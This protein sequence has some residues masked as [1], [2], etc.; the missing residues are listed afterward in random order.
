MRFRILGPLEVWS[1]DDWIDIGAAKWRSLLACLLLR[2][3]QIVSTETLILELW[4]DNPPAKANNLV[5]IY[6]HRLRRVIGDAEGRMLVYRAPGY[7][8]RVGPDDTDMQQ[9]ESL[10]GK[11]RG[12][13]DDGD[14]QAAADLLEQ[15]LGLWR[16]PLLADVPPSEL[17]TRESER[18]AELRLAATELLIE[19]NL[20]CG[21]FAQV[22]P[23][24][25]RLVAENP[26]REGLWLQL[27][28]ALKGAGRHAEALE[29][30]GQARE[31]ISTELG[32]D[33]GAELQRLYAELLT[34]DA[35]GAGRPA[36][37]RVSAETPQQMPAT[38]DRASGSAD[39]ATGEGAEALGTISLGMEP[40]DGA[41][42]E[43][44]SATADVAS[45]D[46]P[47]FAKTSGQSFPR[48]A[49]LP[50]DIED[51]TGRGGHVRHLCDLLTRGHAAS[52][53]GT[54]PVA[55]VAG[56]GG[57]G[58]TTLA[59]HA[60]HRVKGYF[61]DGQLYADLLGATEQPASPGD[62]LA[63]FLR[64]L[65]VE[66]TKV[67][68][69]GEERAALYR[70]TLTGRR[71]LI[72]LDNARDAA[73]V[74]PLLPGSES[75]AVLVTARNR[76]SDLASTRYVDLN[77]LSDDEA[78]AL[79][80]RV[81]GDERPENEP[82]ATAEV[83]LA[84]AGLPL[85]IRI[86]AARLA[87]R[88]QWKIATMANRLRNEQ[89][90]LDELQVGDLEVR[91]SFQVS[92]DSLRPGKHGIDPAHAFRLLGL[93]QGTTISLPAATALIGEAEGD[94]A[95][96][97][98][99]LVDANLLESP[100]P[101]WYR[102]HDLLRFYAGERAKVE[103]T[104]QAR[105]EA[106]GRLLSWYV[107]TADT[108]AQICSPHRYRIPLEGIEEVESLWLSDS[109]DAL[110]WYDRERVNVVS[111]IR[112]AAGSGMDG[113]A[114]QLPISLFS[115]FNRRNNWADC[116]TTHRVALDSARRAGH[117]QAEGLVLNNLGYALGRL[118]D[119]EAIGHLE[120]AM[121]IRHE[122][123]DSTGEAQAAISLGEVYRVLRGPQVALD[124]MLRAMPAFRATGQSSLH[125]AGLVNL[126]EIYLDL[127]RLDEAAKCFEQARSIFMSIDAS[128]GTGYALHNL[129]RV[130]LELG[131]AG[132]ALD[133]LEQALVTHRSTGDQFN[134]ALTL[135]FLGAAQRELGQITRARDSWAAALAVF[136]ALHEDGE[137]EDIQAMMASRAS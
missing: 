22:I 35:S 29:A 85:A 10:A 120:Q 67:P 48:P 109:E 62:V 30:Y 21:R 45:A 12:A 94:V 134:E 137:I 64:D 122:I 42:R 24:L 7:L 56:A 130:Y 26:L 118:R 28:R 58:K 68:V 100:G 41:A 136:T 89:R 73:Q 57:L 102:F 32:V 61:P 59:V 55:L 131:R 60:A 93:W 90:R 116:V 114:W 128:Y 96:V 69:G 52:S 79:F 133:C 37:S 88:G 9:F 75:C 53:P 66:G 23:E 82:D 25:R 107:R 111:A 115:V 40:G 86:C 14:P 76:M 36:P 126:G 77:V 16:G 31:A 105:S 70:T 81:V 92:Y 20:A 49:Q 125:G 17:V 27:M 104:A 3:G 6:V 95:D 132:K 99:T 80:T 8:L 18:T 97:L 51:F 13:L 4:G 83:L 112:Q 71:M 65:G 47:N 15:A 119:K 124:H 19:T 123:S 34:A 127:G 1:G 91:A 2:P 78:L 84:C 108:T 103:E 101:D 38:Q 43:D 39:K 63:R 5:S 11:G 50:A 74:R 54:V 98:E 117:R 135:K 87:A 106:I 44:F 72:V 33:P 110:A 121:S 113:V 46:S 129:G